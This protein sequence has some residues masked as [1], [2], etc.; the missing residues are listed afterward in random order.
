IIFW[1]D[2]SSESTIIQS[3]KNIQAKYINILQKSSNFQI[4]NESSTLDWISEFHE[5]WLLIYDNADHHNIS[6]L[7]KYFPSGQKGNIL[8]TNHNP[9]LSCITENAEIAVA[10]M[11]SKTAIELFCNAS[12]LKE[13]NDKIKR[14]AKDIVIKLS[15]IPL[16]IDLAESSIQCGHYTIYDYL[17][18]F[19]ENHKEG[20]TETSISEKK[21]KYI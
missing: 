2:A 9:N 6:L 1:I 19:D 17:K 8:I 10:E 21:R 5:E 3:L 20:L 11:D 12:G 18:F 15:Y 16:A 7:Q 4:N 13:V 14:Y